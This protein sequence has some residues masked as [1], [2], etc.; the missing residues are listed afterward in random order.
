M[1]ERMLVGVLALFGFGLPINASDIGIRLINGSPV[2]DGT[3]PDVVRIESGG[4]FCT[5]TVVGTRVIATAAHCAKQGAIANFTVKGTK[6]QAK[7]YRSPIYP[8]KDHDIAIGITT[9][10]IK[11]VEPV[12]I[13]GKATVGLGITLMGYGCVNP[14]GGGG[15]DG[16]LRVGDTVVTSFSGYDMVSRKANGAAL[17]FGDSGGP[18]F[19]KQNGKRYL[20]GINSK[21]NIQDTNYN[22]RTDSSDSQNFLQNVA[23]QNGVSICGVGTDCGSVPPPPA[24]TCTLSA[25]PNKI[26]MGQSSVLT[27]ITQGSATEALIDGNPVAIPTGQKSVSPQTAGM[28]SYT[29]NVKGAGGSNTCKVEVMVENET[30]PPPDPPTCTL[31]AIPSDIKL[32]QSLTLELTAKGQVTAAAIEGSSVSLP[33]GKKLVTPS[34]NGTFSATANVTGPGGSNSC[35]VSY[36]VSNDVPPPP[37]DT[38][39]FAAVPTFCGENTLM[40]TKVRKVCLAVFKKDE[41]TMDLRLHEALLI[42][43]ADLSREVMPIISR[44]PR[45]ADAGDLKVQEDLTLYSNSTINAKDY[46]VLDTRQATLTKLPPQVRGGEVPTAIEGRSAKGQYFIVDKLEPFAVSK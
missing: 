39:N 9:A 12:N 6:Y 25:S 4:S 24:P 10:D 33:L 26:K 28:H 46:L 17:C 38:P 44:R 27:L 31:T 41:T 40:Q 5:A 19:V 8:G 30:P 45:L 2:A 16:I 21:G 14:G 11:N 34:A 20:L 23:G 35:W 18:A 37:P 32:G 29:A 42:Q 22:T 3:Y 13:G 1:R 7:I 15:N 36:T 43:Y